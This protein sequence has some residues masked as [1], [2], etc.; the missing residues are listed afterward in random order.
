MIPITGEMIKTTVSGLHEHN[1]LAGGHIS[2][3]ARLK[4]EQLRFLLRGGE[5]SPKT[6]ETRRSY[7]YLRRQPSLHPKH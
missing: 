2:F 3:K 7:K 6:P 5:A 1:R 4:D